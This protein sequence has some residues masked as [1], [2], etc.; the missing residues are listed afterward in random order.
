MNGWQTTCPS[1]NKA[2]SPTV[3]LRKCVTHTEVSTRTILYAHCFP[4]GYHLQFLLCSPKFSKPFCAFPCY[5]RFKPEPD[6]GS[7]FLNA[8]QLCRLVK[9]FVF[10]I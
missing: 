10:Y 9:Q 4:T 8:G 7:F 6:K 5:K 1:F 3:P 2:S